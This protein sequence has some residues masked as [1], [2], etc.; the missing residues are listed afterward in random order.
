MQD[1]VSFG[2][3]DEVEIGS[4]S[5]FTLLDEGP[6]TFVVTGFKR[7]RFEGSAKMAGYGVPLD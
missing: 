2:F 1:N 3:D 5:S 7:G 6:A 4:T